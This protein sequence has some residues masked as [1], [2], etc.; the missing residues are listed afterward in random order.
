MIILVK[1]VKGEQHKIFQFKDGS[2]KGKFPDV[3]TNRAGN[4]YLEFNQDWHIRGLEEIFLIQ[5]DSKAVCTAKP[6]SFA[7]K[8][9]VPMVTLKNASKELRKDVWIMKVKEKDYQPSEPS[10]KGEDDGSDQNSETPADE[11]E[12]KKRVVN[13]ICKSSTDDF[14]QCEL[15][16]FSHFNPDLPETLKT[17]KNKGSK[18]RSQEIDMNYPCLVYNIG[19]RKIKIQSMATPD[20]CAT[21][22]LYDRDFICFAQ[23]KDFTDIGLVDKRSAADK[24]NIPFEETG[25]KIAF[26]TRNVSGPSG[27]IFLNILHVDPFAS[28]MKFEL[29]TTTYEAGMD[30]GIRDDCIYNAFVMQVTS[31]RGLDIS[32]VCQYNDAIIFDCI[33]STK[34]FPIRFP[35]PMKMDEPKEI[36]KYLNE[37]EEFVEWEETLDICKGAVP[38]KQSIQ[39]DQKGALYFVVKTEAGVVKVLRVDPNAEMGNAGFI[40]CVFTLRCEYIHFLEIGDDNIFYLMDEKKKIRKLI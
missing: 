13:T 12:T 8:S 35:M 39:M 24:E 17:L 16:D 9:E 10:D 18:I 37:V 29:W 30:G 1:G 20:M 36:R 19:L 33:T 2:K 31:V 11:G 7:E 23:Y 26:L 38:M 21:F 15:L 28:P 6:L 5:T 14:L 32:F 40:K 3:V 25:Q 4:T 34:Q 27:E 22:N